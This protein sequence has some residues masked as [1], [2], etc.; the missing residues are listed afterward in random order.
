MLTKDYAIDLNSAGMNLISFYG[1]PEDRS[2]SVV[3]QGLGGNISSVQTEGSSA[4][5]S[6][7]GWLGSLAADGVELDLQ[8]GYWVRM[9][10]DDVLGDV[11]SDGIV[12]ILDIVQ[13]VNY[14]LDN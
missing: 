3:M 10:N 8:S 9:E 5:L 11:N 14:I 7:T 1:L 6:Y 2:V 4:L 12:D 13:I